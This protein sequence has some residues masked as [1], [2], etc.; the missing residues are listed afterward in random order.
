[1]TASPCY[2]CDQPATETVQVLGDYHGRDMWSQWI[3]HLCPEC[4]EV[5]R[6]RNERKTGKITGKENEDGIARP[7][8]GA[9]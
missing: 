8:P 7:W 5:A 4:A 1:M 6:E 3:E 9:T 2:R